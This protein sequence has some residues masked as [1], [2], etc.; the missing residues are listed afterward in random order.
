MIRLWSCIEDSLVLLKGDAGFPPETCHHHSWAYM[1]KTTNARIMFVLLPPL[2]TELILCLRDAT[3]NLARATS[4]TA[5]TSGLCL[6][7]L[8][9]RFSQ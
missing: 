8:G 6:G 3:S 9:K 5:N 4:L 1:A 2:N 7:L